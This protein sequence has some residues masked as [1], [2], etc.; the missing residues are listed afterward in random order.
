MGLPNA[1]HF[2]QASG[3]L[4][5][6]AWLSAGFSGTHPGGG[7]M[8][9]ALA[10]SFVLGLLGAPAALCPRHVIMSWLQVDYAPKQ[11]T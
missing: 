1:M 7:K 9:Q 2:T 4:L 5:A 10:C 6:L 11:W 8:W 3:D